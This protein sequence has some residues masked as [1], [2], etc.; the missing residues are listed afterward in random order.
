MFA[1]IPVQAG[2]H[3]CV[4]HDF[5]ASATNTWRNGFRRSPE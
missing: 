4:H 5:N 1:V 3:L 2:I